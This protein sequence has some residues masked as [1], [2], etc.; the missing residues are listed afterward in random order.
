MICAKIVTTYVKFR[1]VLCQYLLF[2]YLCHK[3]VEIY[4]KIIYPFG[5]GA[6]CRILWL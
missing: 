4:E 5:I 2:H 6:S 1:E 3:F